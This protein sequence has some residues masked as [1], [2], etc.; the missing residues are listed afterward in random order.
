MEYSRDSPA[1]ASDVTDE[2]PNQACTPRMKPESGGGLPSQN[3]EP[4]RDQGSEGAN[5]IQAATLVPKTNR[6]SADH[7]IATAQPHNFQ[8]GRDLTLFA[9]VLW[10][11]EGRRRVVAI[12]VGLVAAITANMFGQVRLNQW[13]GHLFDALGRKDVQGFISQIW[14]FLIIVGFLLAITVIQTFLQERLK[15]RLRE[16]ITRHLLAEWLKPMRVYQLSFAGPY[17]R[18]PDQRVQEDTRLLGDYSADIGFGLVYSL[19]QIA[20]FCRGAVDFVR[21]GHLQGRQLRH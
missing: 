18:N 14:T 4:P 20:L 9:H 10:P 21:A 11:A 1:Q 16:W 5:T 17:G 3:S 7:L 12:F 19:L 6:G 15:F 13:N 8:L 2:R